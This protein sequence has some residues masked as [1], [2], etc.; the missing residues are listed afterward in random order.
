MHTNLFRYPIQCGVFT[1][2]PDEFQDG[3][4][5]GEGQPDEQ[6]D[7]D[8]ADVGHSQRARLALLLLVVTDADARVLPPLVVEH[9]DPTALLKLQN[10]HRDWVAVR[11]TY[12]SGGQQQAARSNNLYH[13]EILREFIYFISNTVFISSSCVTENPKETRV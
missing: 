7:E 2:V 10:R 6:D 3:D 1:R 13:S 12:T 4:D 8:A 5:D 11:R 9:L